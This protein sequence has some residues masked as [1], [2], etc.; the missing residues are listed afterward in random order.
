MK[1]LTIG[2]LGGMGPRATVYFE[3]KLFDK[4][5]GSDQSLP[6]VITIND[7]AVPDR[8]AF[9]CGNGADPVPILLRNA[10]LL[11][12]LGADVLCMP[13]NTAHAECILGRLMD[14]TAL[15]LVDMP[16]AA[17]ALVEAFQLQEVLILGTI[18]TR[19]SSVYDQRTKGA[20]VVYPVQEV[21]EAINGLIAATKQQGYKKANRDHLAGII[22][23][24]HAGAVILACTELSML[25]RSLVAGKIVVDALEALADECVAQIPLPHAINNYKE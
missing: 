19:L 2:V 1:R 21:Q 3:Q 20:R 11:V 12:R 16:A 15:P 25:N 5:E 18:G 10:R 13:C 9:L 8:T 17:M 4:L 7:G 6:R 24:A 14:Q 23:Q 22:R